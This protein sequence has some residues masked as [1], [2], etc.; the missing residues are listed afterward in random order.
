M[1]CNK[2]DVGWVKSISFLRDGAW[3]AFAGRDTS[4]RIWDLKNQR[5]FRV[6]SFSKHARVR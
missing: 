2:A 1:S 6:G 5:S 3:L 4:V